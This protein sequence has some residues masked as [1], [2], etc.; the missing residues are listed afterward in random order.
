VTLT[1]HRVVDNWSVTPATAHDHPLIADFLATTRGLSGRKFA[2]D[3]R[4]VAEQLDSVFRDGATVVRDEDGKVRGYTALHLPHGPQ[5]EVLADFVFAPGTPP[6]VVDD[7]VGS[8]V[9]RFHDEAETIPDAFLR[10]FIGA[11]Q[12]SAI[13]A[14]VRRGAAREGRFIRTRK[15][16]D[17]EDPA[18]LQAAAIDGLTR[19]AFGL[20]VGEQRPLAHPVVEVGLLVIAAM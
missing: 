3:S 7:L 19:A 10:A 2:A 6:N 16:L 11:D 8:A 1:Y 17:D 12:Q 18:A 4:D 5:P 20:C 9:A 13:D 14:L 15:P